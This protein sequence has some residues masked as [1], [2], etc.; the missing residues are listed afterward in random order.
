MI[1]YEKNILGKCDFYK[2]IQ[3]DVL[4]K[5]VYCGIIQISNTVYCSTLI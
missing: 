1:R 4:S 3:G 2:Y 5:L